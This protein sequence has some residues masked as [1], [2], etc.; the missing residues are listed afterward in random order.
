M[1]NRRTGPIPNQVTEV[2][3]EDQRK[4]ILNDPEAV[5]ELLNTDEAKE[6]IASLVDSKEITKIIEKRVQEQVGFQ[7]SRIPNAYKQYGFI[8]EGNRHYRMVE[9]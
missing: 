2:L 7:T 5:K 4:Q 9:I 3:S 1:A 6:Q 8:K